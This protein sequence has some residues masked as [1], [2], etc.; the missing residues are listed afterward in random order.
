MATPRT[1]ESDH[2]RGRKGRLTI[3]AGAALVAAYGIGHLFLQIGSYARRGDARRP[4]ADA[5]RAFMAA[6]AGTPFSIEMLMTIAFAGAVIIDASE[7]AAALS[8]CSS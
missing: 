6:R 3:M 8:S 1:D 7:E 4:D 5:R 2:G